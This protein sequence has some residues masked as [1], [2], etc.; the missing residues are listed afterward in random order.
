MPMAPSGLQ[1]AGPGRRGW[2]PASR[3]GAAW[4]AGLTWRGAWLAGLADFGRQFVV[5]EALVAA[6]G[7]GVAVGLRV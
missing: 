7:G 6:D 3:A 1:T 4:L 2:T 5:Q